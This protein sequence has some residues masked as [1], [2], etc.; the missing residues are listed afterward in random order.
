MSRV[1]KPLSLS[2]LGMA[3]LVAAC[4]EGVI[5][6]PEI[7]GE[8]VVGGI[9]FLDID[10]NELLGA[11]DEPVE[12]ARVLLTV[13]GSGAELARDTTDASGAYV[14][15]GVPVG[16]IELGI[17]PE[18]LGDTLLNVPMDSTQ[19][20]LRADGALVV[21]FGLTYPQLSLDEAR[22]AAIGVPI[23][24]QGI[25]LNQRGQA[26]G[27]AVHIAAAGVAMRVLVPP[28]QQALVGDSV[29]ILGRVG[30][31]LGQPVL[32]DAK[33]YRLVALARDVDPNPTS[34]GDARTAAGGLDAALV[35]F[36]SGTVVSSTVV[37]EGY[38]VEITDGVDTLTVRL[39]SAQGFGSGFP[40][41]WEIIRLAGLLV[42]DD[43]AST[44]SLVPRTPSD[45]RLGPP[46]AP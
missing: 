13:P 4:S 34:M 5:E 21:A 37:P 9:V 33:I 20:T 1:G 41:G 22:D 19:F 42:P 30:R 44:W 24:T 10:G 25:A 36:T 46:P 17:D 29:R 8:G 40:V 15:E 14:M 31:D 45:V 3:A 39:R 27:G 6:P 11:V 23:F 2:V 18:F 12:G 16:A 7:A 35:E 32:V 28:S 38:R 43:G 26:P